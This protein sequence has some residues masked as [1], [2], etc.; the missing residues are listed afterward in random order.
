MLRSSVHAVL[1]RD[2]AAVRRTV[3]AYP[4]DATLWEARP[5]LPNA[6]GTIVLHLAGNIQ[7]YL[8]GVLGGS[9]YQ[10]DRAAEFARRGVTRE[11]LMAEVDA[12]ISAVDRG[13]MSLGD[14]QLATAYPEQ[15]G[16]R[17]VAMG[18]FLVHLA[19]HLTYHLGQLDYHRRVVTG[20]A[21]SINAIPALE[22]PDRSA[23]MR[24]AEPSRVP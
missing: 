7:H 23:S 10:R 14:D 17:S 12:A 8:G 19:V 18:D 22:L 9:G 4:D 1:R 16:G 5:G 3:E 2:L 6:G 24:A 15:I 20:D 13:L 21:Q 11:E